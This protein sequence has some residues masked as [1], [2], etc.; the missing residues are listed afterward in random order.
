MRKCFFI[1]GEDSGDRHAADVI[2]ELRL[3]APGLEIHAFGGERMREAGAVLHYPLPTLSSVAL[4][5]IK[6]VFK[7][8]RLGHLV[9]SL[10]R[11]HSVDTLV[12]VDFPGFNLRVAAAARRQGLRVI[13][14]ISPQVWAWRTG[15]VRGM[16]R[17]L[18]MVLTILPFEERF[19][20]DRGVPARFVGHPLVDRLRER[21]EPMA[22]REAHGL[23]LDPSTRLVGLL[24]G[25]RTSEVARLAPVLAKLAGV[26][27]ERAKDLH[28]VVPKA[29]SI[30]SEE[31]RSHFEGDYPWTLVED[32]AP[33]LRACFRVSVTKSGTSTLENAI[34]GVPQVI[35]YKAGLLE[36]W[37]ARRVV[38][39][40][41][42]GLVNIL[43]GR[44]ICPEFLQ[45]G[46]EAERMA[47][48]VLDLIEDTPR[49]KQMLEDLSAVAESLGEGNAARRAAEQILH[50]IDIS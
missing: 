41:W 15:R 28:F 17:D 8:R 44:E 12:L 31:L 27:C 24:P 46:C 47:P 9:L 23:P 38:H 14:Y 32:P 19:L 11:E 22:I 10:C 25:S 7:F 4:G 29:D 39:V 6:N 5:W 13:Y 35:V 48:V 34:L 26:L 30:S 1:A 18:D 50:Q 16:R 33:D 43:A 42:L 20:S 45:E 21:R 2:R 40:P 3:L 49:R 36:A 37:I